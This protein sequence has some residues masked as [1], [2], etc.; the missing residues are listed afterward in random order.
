VVIV[1]FRDKP[2]LHPAKELDVK[3]WV[4]N[5]ADYLHSIVF[6]K[7]NMQIEAEDLVQETFLSAFKNKDYIFV[8]KSKKLNN[9]KIWYHHLAIK[10]CSRND[11]VANAVF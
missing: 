2:Q 10:N 11:H 4:K 9:A 8:M 6:L 7:T 3:N 5:Y 1:F